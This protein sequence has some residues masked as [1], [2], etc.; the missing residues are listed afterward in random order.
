MPS[1][2]VNKL[3]FYKSKFGAQRVDSMIPMMKKVGRE[4]GIQFSYG[5]NIGNTFDSH[6]LIWKARQQGGSALQDI[7]VEELFKAYFEKEQCLSESVV[8]ETCAQKAGVE[9]LKNADEGRV[10]TQREMAEVRANYG[11]NG[12]PLFVFDGRK[13][14]LSGAQ[15]PEEILRV[16]RKCWP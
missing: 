15:P 7:V 5:G 4:H 16:L 2:G 8:L 14:T 1:I 9:A 13:M 3:D 6:R 12:V 10:E 11:V